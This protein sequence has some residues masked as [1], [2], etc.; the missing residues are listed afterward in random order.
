MRPLCLTLTLATALGLPA[1]L[2]AQARPGQS[3]VRGSV[4]TQEDLPVAQ[5]LVELRI[6]GDS[7]SVRSVQTSEAGRF[8]FDALAEG[9]YHLRIRRIGFGPATTPD[10]TVAAAQVRDLGRIR[11][12]AAAVQLAPIEVTVERPDILFEADRTAYL[13]EALTAAGGGAVNDALRELPDIVVELDGTVRLRGN[14]PAIY[15]N[16][17]PAP[18]QGVSLAV[19][20][21]QFPADRIERIEVLEAPPARYSAEGGAGIINIVLK[22]G[23][24]VGVTGN[25]SLSGGTRG[26][27]STSGRA[28]W[29][30]GPLVL[31]GGLDARW[32]DSRNADF[33][34]RQNLLATPL[35]FLR[36]DARSDRANRN[37][38]INLDAR[39][40]FSKKS[41]VFARFGG[42]LNGND[43]D[44]LT[45]TAHLDELQAPTLLYG[46][47]ATQDGSGKSADLRTGFEY[48]WV[49]ERH[50]FSIEA[51]AQ[52]NR[53]RNETREEI[54]ADPIYQ[55]DELLPA[56]LT[57][58]DDGSR[59]SGV[60]MEA[61]YA[62]PIGTLTRIETGTSLR[63]SSSKEDQTV[64]LFEETGATIP[65]ELETR[66]ISR[67]QRIA[68]AYFSMNRRL[69]KF[70]VSAGVRGEWVGEDIHFPAGETVDRSEA[71]LFPTV[72][73]NWNPRQR[74]QVR[75]NYG[76]RVNRP[77]V[78]VL[79]PT[80]RSIDPLNRSVGN[81]DIES[82]TTHSINLG[83][84]WTG[85]L[86][87]LS[88]GP[89]WS[90]TNNG[91]ERV[92]TVDAEGISTS[93]W[94]NL[95]S[96][97]N[98]GSSLGYTAPRVWG[99]NARIN[100][101]ASRSTLDGSLRPPGAEDGKLRW[102]VGGNLTGPV[103]QGITAQGNFGYEPG[104]DL[105]QGRTSGQWRA[106]FSFRY[107]LM[108]NRTSIGLSVQDPFELR[109]TTQ[110]IRDPSVVQT[111]QNRVTT[112]SMTLNV[113][114]AF[115]GG[116]GNGP[117][118]VRRD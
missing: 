53:N 98:L 19:F 104:R 71:N 14:T 59:T 17:R 15:L 82:S 51:S 61:N 91:W 114:Y 9:V 44:G 68:S 18:M 113:S 45:E 115:G 58:R 25:L 55:D 32:S 84:N 111:S 36:Q 76:R 27:Y 97:T 33:T 74:M 103:I 31:N 2:P 16:G 22:E 99:W 78:S 79:D 92:T 65:D 90:R 41:R 77:G 30:R 110:Q 40:D 5:A 70:G 28:T 87:Q 112:R 105:V 85:R 95:T 117:G 62:R 48:S 4:V 107:R 46:R 63:S 72:N 49:P 101:S 64:R 26:Q 39:Y 88:F 60:S 7:A 75:M 20:L 80:N 94:A 86:G 11:L 54:A 73:L 81:P 24:E 89:Y 29:Q 34:L 106:D 109:K 50:T 67:D 12:Q 1:S 42:N 10:F 47:L 43:R 56:W 37:G 35:T 38:G 23:V 69:G 66:L 13:V 83:F 116:R 57:L 3:S 108:G 6:R 8:Q 118:P 96:R 93:T 102:S 52:V 100:L 21:E